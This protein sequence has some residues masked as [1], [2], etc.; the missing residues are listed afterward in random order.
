MKAAIRAV[1]ESDKSDYHKFIK[2]APTKVTLE[3]VWNVS[4]WRSYDTM[5]VVEALCEAF[6]ISL[7]D[8]LR[9]L[10]LSL[11]VQFCLAY[12][13]QEFTVTSVRDVEG[14]ISICS[15]AEDSHQVNT[16]LL[17][18]KKGPGDK[19]DQAIRQRIDEMHTT[20]LAALAEHPNWTKVYMHQRSALMKEIGS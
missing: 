11:D 18:Y 3:E 20:C 2:S 6:M 17:I 9:L 15:L 13:L 4:E 19:P 12:D 8:E 14:N 7:T 16:A 1:M 10:I 5:L